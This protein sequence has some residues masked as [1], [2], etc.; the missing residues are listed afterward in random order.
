MPKEKL[1]MRNIGL[2]GLEETV[3]EEIDLISQDVID[4]FM[5]N[6]PR[7]VIIEIS[8]TP[9]CERVSGDLINQP[10]VDFSVKHVMP[11]NKGIRT[12]AFIDAK[13][14]HLMLNTGDPLGSDSRQM[15][16]MDEEVVH[17]PA[18]EPEPVSPAPVEP[19]ET[20]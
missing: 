8:I 12:R 10:N 6:K 20:Q 2:G 19:S 14:E 7:K 16:I 17:S 18:P 3:D 11:G 15:T 9:I 13:N 4:R 1:C 5:I